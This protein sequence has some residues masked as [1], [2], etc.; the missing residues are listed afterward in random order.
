MKYTQFAIC[1]SWLNR[2]YREHKSLIT[3]ERSQDH[4]RYLFH[5]GDGLPLYTLHSLKSEGLLREFYRQGATM[6]PRKVGRPFIVLSEGPNKSL[7]KVWTGEYWQVEYMSTSDLR[8]YRL[9]LSSGSVG[10]LWG[11]QCR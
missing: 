3:V 10:V 8:T 4:I 11:E 2:T 9:Y 1:D 5:A 6:I 7:L